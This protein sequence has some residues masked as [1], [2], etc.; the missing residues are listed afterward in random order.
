MKILR[1][2][3]ENNLLPVL[4]LGV[5]VSAGFAAVL[6]ERLISLIQSGL[7]PLMTA[8][9][10]FVWG[11]FVLP[12]AGMLLSL[13]FVRFVV[14]DDIGHG[15]T[16]VLLAL[17]RGDARIRAH[18]MGSSIAASAMTMTGDIEMNG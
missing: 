7:M 17:S 5:G 9:D 16:K 4:S 12:G 14:R 10:G 15:V 1:K 8:Q 3:S 11:R 2:I 18:N 13:L 6:L